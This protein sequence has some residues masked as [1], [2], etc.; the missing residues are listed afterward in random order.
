MGRELVEQLVRIVVLRVAVD[1]TVLAVEVA[2]LLSLTEPLLEEGGNVVDHTA[3]LLVAVGLCSL[4]ASGDVSPDKRHGD[5]V[6]H[7]SMGGGRGAGLDGGAGRGWL[8]T[9][10]AERVGHGANDG[11]EGGGGGD[12]ARRSEG[13]SRHQEDGEQQIIKRS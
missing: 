12:R 6:G 11:W 3:K 8:G 7:G 10:D 13:Q 5:G 9:S 2:V 4:E 1:I